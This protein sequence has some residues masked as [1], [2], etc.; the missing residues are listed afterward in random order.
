MNQTSRHLFSPNNRPAVFSIPC[1]CPSSASSLFAVCLSCVEIVYSQYTSVCVCGGG[2]R[3]CVCVCVCVCACVS[4]C[5]RVC[6]CVCVCARARARACGG[7]RRV[8]VCVCEC[9]RAWCVRGVCVSAYAL[10]ILSADKIVHYTYTFIIIIYQR[11]SVIAEFLGVLPWN[12]I[13]LSLC[14]QPLS[15]DISL[16]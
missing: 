7:G 13:L 2:V 1:C 14:S 4:A 16:S 12:T 8:C 15:D 10:I 5:V 3:L 11:A 6:V 9:V